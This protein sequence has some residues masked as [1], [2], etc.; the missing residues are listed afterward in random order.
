MFVPGGLVWPKDEVVAMQ[1][2]S[3]DAVQAGSRALSYLKFVI[4]EDV[5]VKD[6]PIDVPTGRSQALRHLDW[7]SDLGRERRWWYRDDDAVLE[8]GRGG[9]RR[10]LLMGDEVG[11]RTEPIDWPG[12]QWSLWRP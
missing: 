6:R 2:D 9:R 7:N 8:Q 5:G 10:G 12:P 11:P 3:A 4:D 1:E